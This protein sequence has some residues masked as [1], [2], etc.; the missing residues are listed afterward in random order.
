MESYQNEVFAPIDVD[1]VLERV[2]G[3]NETDVYRSDDSRFVV[4]LKGDLS[5]RDVGAM[6]HEARQMKSAAQRFA[7]CLGSNHAIPTYFVLSRDQ[8]GFVHILA[9]QPYLQH[10]RVLAAVDWQ[11]IPANHRRR[12]GHD[13]RHIIF[14]AIG[15]LLSTG[16]LPDLYGRVSSSPAE[17]QRRKQLRYLPERIWSFLVKR[18]ITL[19]KW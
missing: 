8:A 15:C 9:I 10:A 6:L 19:P 14:R 2:A 5:S 3:G 7:A 18:T 17:R 4:K 11:R 12:I 1:H 16:H 13:L